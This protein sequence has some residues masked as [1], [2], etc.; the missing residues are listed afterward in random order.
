MVM[1]SFSARRSGRVD[2]ESRHGRNCVGDRPSGKP[3][4]RLV[5]PA[6]EDVLVLRNPGPSGIRKLSDPARTELSVRFWLSPCGDN[7]LAWTA[8]DVAHFQLFADLEDEGWHQGR[9]RVGSEGRPTFSVL[10]PVVETL[11]SGK[12]AARMA[13]GEYLVHTDL[14]TLDSADESTALSYVRP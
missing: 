3:I 7:A 6:G 13:G 12:A 11:L 1:T 5:G 9:V 2:I 8:G 4:E 14:R 10:E